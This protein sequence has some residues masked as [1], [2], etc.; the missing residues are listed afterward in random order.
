MTHQGNATPP[1][2]C[3]ESSRAK[4]LSAGPQLLPIQRIV[5]TGRTARTLRMTAGMGAAVHLMAFV[6]TCTS[7]KQQ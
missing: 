3:E 6:D 4:M 7:I 1:L 5:Q 2:L